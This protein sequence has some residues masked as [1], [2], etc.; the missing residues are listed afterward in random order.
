MIRRKFKIWHIVVCFSEKV[1][2]CED[3]R[4][5]KGGDYNYDENNYLAHNY[6]NLN[7]TD[8]VEQNMEHAVITQEN[9]IISLRWDG[10]AVTEDCNITYQFKIFDEGRQIYEKNIK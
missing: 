8:I 2:I 4:K 1:A 7:C 3:N 10:T 9:Y 6:E 5:K